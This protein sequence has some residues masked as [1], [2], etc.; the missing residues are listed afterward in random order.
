ML[1]HLLGRGLHLLELELL[2]LLE[3]EHHHLLGR[4]LHPLRNF[5]LCLI[6]LAWGDLLK[7]LK[8]DLLNPVRNLPVRNLSTVLHVKVRPKELRGR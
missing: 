5:G 2:H 4:E 6:V 7:K 8:V 1:H 3:L